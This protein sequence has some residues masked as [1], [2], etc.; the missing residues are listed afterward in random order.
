[1]WQGGI[2]LPDCPVCLLIF[3]VRFL[4]ALLKLRPGTFL[5]AFMIFQS[6]H[7]RFQQSP[8]FHLHLLPRDHL[9]HRVLALDPPPTEGLDLVRMQSSWYGVFAS[10]RCSSRLEYKSK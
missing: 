9:L 2:G 8:L 10:H 4:L 6:L 3:L 7:P 5:T 1:M